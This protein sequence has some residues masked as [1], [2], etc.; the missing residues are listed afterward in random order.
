LGD[1]AQWFDPGAFQLAESG[2]YG[3]VPRNALTGPSFAN[4][5]LSVAKALF[6]R[7][8]RQLKFR[9]DLFNLFNRPNF[10]TPRNPTGAQVS[11]GVLVF[12][13][14]SGMAAESAGQIFNTA[15]DSRQIQ[16]SLRYSF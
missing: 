2:Y 13:D 14:A 6:S 4:V 9:V 1:P 11:Q 15:S 7:E 8:T 16:F 12:P 10:A 3:N 5:D